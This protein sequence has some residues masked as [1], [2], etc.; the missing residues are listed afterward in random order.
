[1]L[2]FYYL[3]SKPDSIVQGNHWHRLQPSHK[4]LIT[5]T[6]LSMVDFAASYNSDANL[7]NRMQHV[8]GDR[9]AFS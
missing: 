1:M 5:D 8:A 7:R 3:F 9:Y 2:K 6:L 4:R